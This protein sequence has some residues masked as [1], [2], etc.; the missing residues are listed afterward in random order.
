MKCNCRDQPATQRVDRMIRQLFPEFDYVDTANWKA[1]LRCRHCAQLWAVDEWD[2]YQIQLAV[3]ITDEVDWQTSD[4]AYRK[5]H[6][7]QSRGGT[8]N[9]NCM[10]SDCSNK[11]L[12]GSAYCVDHLYTTSVRD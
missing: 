9:A 11:Q 2:K 4:E 8:G 12:K 6:L 10:W 3:K 1:L 5:A 7:T